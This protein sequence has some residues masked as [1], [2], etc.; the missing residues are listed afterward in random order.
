MRN[1]LAVLC[2]V[3]SA[4]VWGADAISLKNHPLASILD[5]RLIPA[6]D[7]VRAK[8]STDA[9]SAQAIK[10]A[11]PRAIQVTPKPEHLAVRLDTPVTPDSLQ[12]IA[13]T[14]ATIVSSSARWNTVCVMAT[15]SQI[16]ALTSVGGVRSIRLQGRAHRRTQGNAPNKGD[17]VM[18]ADQLRQALSVTGLGQKIGVISDSVNQTSAVGQGTVTGTVPNASVTGM[19][20]QGTG[21]LPSSFQVIDFGP[22]GGTDEGEAMMEVMYDVAPGASFAFS[23]CSTDQMMCATNLLLLQ[24]AAGCTLTVDDIGFSDEPFFQDGPIAQAAA[25][26][27]AAGILHFSAFGNDA[28]QAILTT[29]KT[30]DPAQTSDN[31]AAPPDGSCFHDW[32]GGLGAALPVTIPAGAF[33]DIILQWDQPYASY[34]LGAGSSVDL[35]LYLSP[36][37]TFNYATLVGKSETKQFSNGTTPSGDPYEIISYANNGS[38]KTLYLFVNHFQGSRTGSTGQ[39]GN[40]IRVVFDDDGE[41][42][43][44]SSKA[45]GFSGTNGGISAYGHPTSQYMVAVGAIDC[46][47]P[48]LPEPF[49]GKGGMIPYYFNPSGG[50]FFFQRNAPDLA[51]PDGVDTLKFGGSDTDG[52]GFPNFYGTSCAAPNACAVAALLRQNTPSLSPSALLAL[53]T[54]TAT[55]ITMPP[56]EDPT[57]QMPGF[58]VYTGFGLV[59]AL[60]AGS[61][62]SAPTITSALN[63][64]GNVGSPF[65][66][67]IT[68]TGAATII[69]TATNLP[70]GL[71]FDGNNTISGI[72]TT[73]GTTN[74]VLSAMNQKGT[75][76]ATLVLTIGTPV[77]VTIV[78]G[79]TGNPNPSFV[80][81]SVAFTINATGSGQGITA[82]WTFG[83]G[84]TATGISVQHAYTAQGSYPVNV[85]LVD[86]NGQTAS[87][88][89]T[90]TVVPSVLLAF[91][92]SPSAAPNPAGV[93]EP[94]TFMA[95]AAGNGTVTYTWDFGDGTATATGAIVTHAYSTSGKFAATVT[96]VDVTNQ[97]AIATVPVSITATLIGSGPD[98]DGDGVS[99]SIEILAGTNPNDPNSTPLTNPIPQTLTQKSLVIRL[100]FLRAPTSI[101]SVSPAPSRSPREQ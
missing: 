29:F 97:T 11:N 66:Y 88:S 52:D 54:Q 62:N 30:I 72:P 64:G 44:P 93:G 89:L 61:N 27:Q 83:D 43:L 38:A 91:T 82:M 86:G 85:N 59:N 47:F 24:S 63:A 20:P 49:T 98:S 10:T 22:Q 1:W 37:S 80:G 60:A 16:D 70:P 84:G 81:V 5:E 51:A 76:T 7:A 53:M 31:L 100:N 36:T 79:P 2:I 15:I 46:H 6:V 21:D 101:Q 41:G 9:Q 32:G 39:M 77:P 23:S 4:G 58:D 3:L 19:I 57:V 87:G 73:Q 94:A 99:D 68:A 55:D 17:G 28:N 40:N 50:N 56:T 33:V 12:R 18:K 92:S 67:T 14:G 45:M 25:S 78:S 90:E 71:T 48:T 13:A 42:T 69:F 75:A 35:D 8:N 26:N 96:A 34:G 65:S 95:N 74:V